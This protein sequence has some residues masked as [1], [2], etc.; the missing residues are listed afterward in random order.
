M[1]RFKQ[2]L[3]SIKRDSGQNLPVVQDCAYLKGSLPKPKLPGAPGLPCRQNGCCGI[4]SDTGELL[5]APWVK[6]TFVPFP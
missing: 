4:L 3:K 5:M 1:M 2:S 6:G